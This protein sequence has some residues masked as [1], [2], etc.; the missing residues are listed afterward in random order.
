MHNYIFITL[1]PNLKIFIIIMLFVSLSSAVLALIP[2]VSDFIDAEKSVFIDAKD[3][4]HI[5]LKKYVKYA[6]II[7]LI[8]MMILVIFPRDANLVL[9]AN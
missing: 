4:E 9:M 1:L 8:C 5:L 2:I 3:V 6:L 7:S